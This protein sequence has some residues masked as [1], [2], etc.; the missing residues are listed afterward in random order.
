MSSKAEKRGKGGKFK[1]NRKVNKL[2]NEDIEYLV[3]RYFIKRNIT[4]IKNFLIRTS[5][6]AAEIGEWY[7]G[8]I[9]VK[10]S[11]NNC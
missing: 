9:E 2:S 3:K 7:K 5:Y 8:F 11:E 4:K 1:K 10:I 6:D